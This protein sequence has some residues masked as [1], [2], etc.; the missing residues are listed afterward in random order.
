MN[1]ARTLLHL[2]FLK[3]NRKLSDSNILGNLLKLYK[4]ENECFI[5]KYTYDECAIKVLCVIIH[6]RW[7]AD[8]IMIHF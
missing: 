1:E 8:L 4:V 7:I 2:V 5:G 6:S 3:N